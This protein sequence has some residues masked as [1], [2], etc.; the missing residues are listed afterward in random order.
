MISSWT[1]IRAL[2]SSV[3]VSEMHVDFLLFI[4]KPVTEHSTLYT[5]MLSVVSTR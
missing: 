4:P 2:I 3:K 1:G 5:S